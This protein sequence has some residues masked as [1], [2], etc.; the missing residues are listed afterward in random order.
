MYDFDIYERA[1]EVVLERDKFPCPERYD[2]ELRLV[3]GDYMTPRK[4]GIV[5]F[6]E[7]E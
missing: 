4:M 6:E 5:H 7:N 3:Y 2:E 1:T